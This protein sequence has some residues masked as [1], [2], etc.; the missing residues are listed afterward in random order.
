MP[1]NKAEMSFRSPPAWLEDLNLSLTLVFSDG[2]YEKWIGRD[3]SEINGFKEYMAMS[4]QK[5]EKK[6][7]GDS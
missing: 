6:I 4:S 3:G 1:E 5:E 2:L 7:V